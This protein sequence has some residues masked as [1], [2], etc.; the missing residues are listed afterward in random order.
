M[1][2]CVNG[3]QNDKK[4]VNADQLLLI[5]LSPPLFTE[6]KQFFFKKLV[7]E[8]KS[9]KNLLNVILLLLNREDDFLFPLIS[10]FVAMS[11]RRIEFNSVLDKMEYCWGVGRSIFYFDA[12]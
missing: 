5:K 11:Q 10:C 1:L 2:K 9:A 6:K 8:C 12:F 7:I 4:N 3:N